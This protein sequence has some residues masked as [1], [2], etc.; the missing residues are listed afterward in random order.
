MTA[1]NVPQP[2]SYTPYQQ[3]LIDLLLEEVTS[4]SVHHL[5]GPVGTGKSI[6]AAGAVTALVEAGRASRVLVLMPAMLGTQWTELLKQHGTRALMLDGRAIRV[7]RNEFAHG[8]D[9]PKGVFVMSI[10]LAKRS[11]VREWISMLPWDFVLIDEADRLVGK[12]GEITERGRLVSA[13]LDMPSPPSA[14]IVTS[15]PDEGTHKL[16]GKMIDI[17]WRDAVKEFLGEDPD[18][19]SGTVPLVTRMYRRTPDEVAVA[20]D[21]VAAARRLGRFKGSVLMRMAASSVLS[22]E[23]SLTR[24]VAAD[25]ADV[26]EREILESLLNSVESLSV[27]SKLDCLKALVDELSG[28]GIRHAI[29]FCDFKATLD[30]LHSALQ[31]LD[32]ADYVVH[33]G[34]TAEARAT[35][36]KR[37][38][39]TGGFLIATTA[40]SQFMSMS[41]VQA[42]VHY[43]FPFS[44]RAFTERM[45]R[46]RQYGSGIACTAY[47]FADESTALPI[48]ALQLQ[49]ALGQDLDS[50]EVDPEVVEFID[51]TLP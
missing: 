42:I 24:Q 31:D 5:T 38:G 50:I 30:Y 37:F 21:V 27:D 29:V 12:G 44:P 51:R 39:E 34:M 2:F 6:G 26:G 15:F 17:D 20:N 33:G 3:A 45:G 13:L 49:L 4:G 11:D 8:G 48:E 22:L 28:A 7:M 16:V 23:E 35:V 41:F 25:Q 46:H 19:P 47:C 1:E 9:L 43:D 32:L 14:L 36:L 18:H 40:A 10:D